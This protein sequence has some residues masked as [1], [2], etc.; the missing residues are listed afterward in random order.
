MLTKK[1]FLASSSELK[2][3]RKEFEIFINGKNRDLV[4]R[5]VFLELIKWEDF[6]DPV[7]KTRLQD[8]YNKA[9]REC[10]IFIMLFFTKVGQYTEEE[11]ETAFG[12]FKATNKPLIY[13]YFK[14]APINI[15][16]ADR[17]DL[18]SLWSFKDK[19]RDLGHFYTLYKNID[20][21]KFHFN[22]QLDKLS[23]IE[24]LPDTWPHPRQRVRVFL[25]AQLPNRERCTSLFIAQ[26]PTQP[27]FQFE[28]GHV[29][30]Y[31][32]KAVEVKL[33]SIDPALGLGKFIEQF[34]EIIAG[35]EQTQAQ[36]S[37]P[38]PV[39][40]VITHAPLPRKFYLWGHFEKPAKWH[41]P[42]KEQ[43]GRYEPNKF[44]IISL[45]LFEQTLPSIPVERFLLRVIQRASVLALVP[46]HR[47]GLPDR[48]IH[49]STTG[50]LFDFTRLLPEAQYFTAGGFICDDCK[51]SILEAD[52]IP[53]HLRS[54]FLKD[55]QAWLDP[56]SVAP[57]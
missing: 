6:L 18:T 24:P 38:N 12:Q 42:P 29:A 32:T 41:D 2:D 37:S 19:L 15:G 5:G 35:N 56:S 14:D 53:F 52:E 44:W 46:V 45:A 21:L 47:K 7:S 31:D 55:L 26:N 51:S 10:D 27:F 34:E 33:R 54:D 30:G 48:L 49:D 57:H 9:I 23:I 39:R 43:W 25:L 22:Q 13:T 20:E 50:C 36:P 1:I 4:N 3:D 40:I 11:F 16:S 8:E 28:L 17:N